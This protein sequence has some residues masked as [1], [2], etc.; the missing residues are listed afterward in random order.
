[1]GDA[2][3]MTTLRTGVALVALLHVVVPKVLGG[4]QPTD[5]TKSTIAGRED[6][7]RTDLAFFAKELPARHV[8]AFKYVTP[9]AFARAVAEVDSAIP[10][11]TD[12]QIRWRLMRLTALVR[13]GHT[14]AEMAAA[15][16]LSIRTVE[17]HRAS[18]FR[19]LRVNSRSALVSEMRERLAPD[20]D[21]S[22]RDRNNNELG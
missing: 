13:D 1:M 15:L 4:Q 3:F 19:K 22:G 17:H 16:H 2:R 7:W 14:N 5:S 21:P 9:E 11:L 12:R 10:H 6:N 8:N 18:V 20:T